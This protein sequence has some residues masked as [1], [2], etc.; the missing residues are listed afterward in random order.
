MLSTAIASG[1]DRNAKHQ[2]W[3]VVGTAMPSTSN[4]KRSGPQCQAHSNGKRSKTRNT[5]TQPLLQCQAK[6]WQEAVTKQRPPA[7]WKLG[8][9]MMCQ[10]VEVGYHYHHYQHHIPQS[11]ESIL[12]AGS[13][14]KPAR[15]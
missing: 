1:Q 12:E 8:W 4:G 14:Q 3:Q 11:T 5:T 9:V 7:I 6:Q 13:K 15:G 2:Q 10:W